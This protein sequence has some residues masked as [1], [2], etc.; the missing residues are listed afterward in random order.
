LLTSVL[1]FVRECISHARMHSD[2]H[3]RGRYDLASLEALRNELGLTQAEVCRALAMS[4]STYQRW[5]KHI[6]GLPGGVKPQPRSLKALR[7]VLL[8]E[9]NRRRGVQAPDLT[10]PAA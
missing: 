6:A 3:N 1:D 4:P 8:A 2:L 10:Q 5:L 9:A 7:D